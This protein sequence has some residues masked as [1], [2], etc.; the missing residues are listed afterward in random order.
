[1]ECELR[2]ELSAF[3]EMQEA[4]CDCRTGNQ[5]MRLEMQDK[6]EDGDAGQG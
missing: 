4:C 1:M 5:R 6:D 3:V 2:K